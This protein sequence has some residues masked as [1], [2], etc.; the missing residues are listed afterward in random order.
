MAKERIY[1]WEIFDND[2]CGLKKVVKQIV[3]CGIVRE[4]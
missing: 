3:K 2:L 4:I 1:C